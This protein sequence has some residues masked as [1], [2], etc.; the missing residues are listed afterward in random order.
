M[1]VT[2]VVAGV[3]NL[4]VEYLS[5]VLKE[6]GHQVSL[7][8]DPKLFESEAIKNS[9]LRRLFDIKNQVVREIVDSE[10]DLIAFSVFTINYQWAL[11]TARSVKK[12]IDTPIIFG[13][14]H[15]TS[16]PEVVLKND[17]VD[18]VCVGEGEYALLE[19]VESLG[20]EPRYDIQ[21][22]WFKR[23]GEIVRND[24]RPLIENLDT[25]PLPDKQL[26]Y[27]K[28]PFLKKDY[29]IMTSRGCPFACTY[30]YNNVL[31]NL[32]RRKGKCYRRRS[33]QNV[34]D[35]LKWAK[36][37]FRPRRI[38]FADDFFVLDAGWLREFIPR[39]KAEIGLPFLVMAHP[40]YIDREIANLLKEGGC[41]WIIM[42]IQS[43]S[44]VTRRR[45]LKRYLK[46]EQIIAAAQACHQVN[47]NFAVDHIFNIPYEG[48]KEQEEAFS[49]YNTIRPAAINAYWLQYFPRTEIIDIA[50]EA[51]IIDNEVIE[52]I[53]RGETSTSMVIGI[54]GRDSINPQKS[55]NN[56]HFLFMVLPL[57]PRRVV[58]K[59][60]ERRWFLSHLRPPL[61]LG[62]FI[63]FIQSLRVRR[64][65]VYMD[66]IKASVYNLFRNMAIKLKSGL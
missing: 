63:K 38:T 55:L 16:V 48:T 21:N 42:G 64:G 54:G 19:L 13:G 44:E 7:V 8:F 34:I 47:L 4:G 46:N 18:M 25:L 22:I 6:H 61:I 60:I 31:K 17:C 53:N 9:R 14:I 5:S 24:V 26:F 36:S 30:C 28:Q 66:M 65:Y 56:F 59:M 11:E 20:E 39:Y 15:A 32:Y 40:N 23:D 27:S 49:F 1:K 50:K 35:E 51:G 58:N 10:P 62:V 37:I 45:V 33:V 52:K 3:E 41:F 12:K 2:F 29:Y 57:L 43:V